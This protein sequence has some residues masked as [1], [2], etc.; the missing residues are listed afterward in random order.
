MKRTVCFLLACSI[1]TLSLATLTV[2]ADRLSEL[3]QQKEELEQQKSELQQQAADTQSAID[4]ANDTASEIQGSIDELSYAMDEVTSSIVEIM[5]EIELLEADISQKEADIVQTQMEYDHAVQVKEEQY[6]AMCIRIKCMY[7]SGD[8][9][10]IEM[11]LTAQSIPDVLNKVDYIEALYQYDRD[12]LAAFQ[13]VVEEVA[14]LEEK[15]ETELASLEES[16]QILAD[17]QAEL[18]LELAQLQAE[19][20]NF[21]LALAEVKVTAASY[22]SQL[23]QQQSQLNSVQNSLNQTNKQIKAEEAAL[24][25][26]ASTT[27]VQKVPAGGATFNASEV[28]NAPGSDKGKQIAVYACSFIGNPYVIGGTSLT[29]GADCSGFTQSV[30]AQFDIKIPRTS[31]EQRSCGVEVAYADAQPGDLICYAGHVAMYIGNGKIVHA[32]SA[33]TGIKISYATYRTILSVRRVL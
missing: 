4:E 5:T 14:A 21:E 1:L 9:T 32:S 33:K 27:T 30:L 11:L 6:Q 3:Q 13:Q 18:D 26:K 23:K 17:A 15:L 12:M 20:D 8:S 16:K 24:A 28:W 22:T 31:Y 2:Y 29:N 25:A 10:Y 7:E 19:S